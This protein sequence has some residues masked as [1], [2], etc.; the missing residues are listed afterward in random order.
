MIYMEVPLTV[1]SMMTMTS[2]IVRR[3]IDLGMAHQVIQ[4][5][6][7]NNNSSSSSRMVLPKGVQR[8]EPESLS[9]SLLGSLLSSL[10]NLHS[11]HIDM[12]FECFYSPL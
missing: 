8:R 6:D 12:K 2:T 11:R 4:N 5:N 1:N 7:N 10:T 9:G 3:M